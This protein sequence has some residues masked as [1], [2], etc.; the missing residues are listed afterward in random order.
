MRDEPRPGLFDDLL[1]LPLRPAAEHSEAEAIR[2]WN[3]VPI[4]GRVSDVCPWCGLHMIRSVAERLAWL[5]RGGIA[6]C[7]GCAFRKIR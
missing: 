4:E 5:R 7:S 1:E 2:L 6:E 3:D